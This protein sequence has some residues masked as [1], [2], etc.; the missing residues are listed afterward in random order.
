MITVTCDIC[1]ERL[2]G[3]YMVEVKVIKT[4]RDMQERIEFHYHVHCFKRIADLFVPKEV[5][6]DVKS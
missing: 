3:D 4:L 6:S 5:I 2:I 1:K